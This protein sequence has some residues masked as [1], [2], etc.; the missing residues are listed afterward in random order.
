MWILLADL[1]VLAHLAFVLFVVLGGVLVWRWPRL[2]W[3]HAPA[4]AW[5]IVVEAA[6]LVCPLTPL[7]L[8]LR[9]RGGEAPYSGDFVAEYVLP[10]LYPAELTRTVQW[11]LAGVVFTINVAIYSAIWRRRRR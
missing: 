7:E 9:A 2:A 6:G 1:V 4:A 8:W 3:I 10:L 11:V 5:G